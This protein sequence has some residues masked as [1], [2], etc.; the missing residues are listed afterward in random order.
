MRDDIRVLIPLRSIDDPGKTRLSS[1]LDIPARK[2]LVSAMFFDLV[3]VLREAELQDIAVLAGD[4]SAARVAAESGCVPVTDTAGA[5]LSQVIADGRRRAASD[6]D[7]LVM[8]PDLPML[9]PGEVRRLVSSTAPV[10][11]APTADGGTGGLLLR[12]RVAMGLQFGPQSASHHAVAC[13]RAGLT[14]EWSRSLGFDLDVDT[15][16]DLARVAPHRLGPA[17]AHLLARQP[18]ADLVAE[19]RRRQSDR[20]RPDGAARIAVTS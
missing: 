9:L 10:A 7:A 14:F 17:T 15:S 13:L 16:E 1:C 11:I 2:E 6:V 12:R 8:M 19:H 3:D 4:R 20:P 5:G 18:F